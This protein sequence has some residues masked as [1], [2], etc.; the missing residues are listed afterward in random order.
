MVR[1]GS[2][3]IDENGKVIGG[4]PGDQTGQEV[5]I[6]PWYLHDK[7]WVIIARRMRISVSVSQSAWKQRVPTI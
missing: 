6:E 5:A 7:G 4:Q 1:V 3:R 2:A